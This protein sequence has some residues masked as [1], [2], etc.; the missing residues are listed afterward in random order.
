MHLKM[1]N[2]LIIRLLVL[3]GLLLVS[4]YACSEQLDRVIAVVEDDAILESEL[5]REVTAIVQKLQASN[6][7]MP[8]EYVVK[9]QVLEKM[10]VERLQRNLAEK[11][12][13]NLSEEVLTNSA[14]DIA[15]RN[16]M[17]L[18]QFKQELQSQ[19]M[20]YQTFLDNMRNEIIINQ[21]RGKEIGENQSYGQ[22]NR[23]LH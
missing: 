12:G 22:G 1:I 18:E 2:K 11:T 20:S 5:I 9:K 4:H 17:T 3:C 13:V 21:L 23:A 7:P 8:P 15:Q 19:G 6:T 10:I 14:T 16:N